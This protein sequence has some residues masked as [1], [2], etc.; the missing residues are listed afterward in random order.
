[1]ALRAQAGY[2]QPTVIVALGLRSYSEAV[3]S[4]IQELRPHLWV[5]VV[6]PGSIEQET[7][8]LAPKIVLCSLPKPTTLGSKC[9]W[10]E[11]RPYEQPTVLTV[12][13][14]QQEMGKPVELTDLVAVIDEATLNGV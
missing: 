10:I 8:R 4:V 11:Y 1:M 2:A 6:D 3:G 7:E 13:G 12:N 5:E 14:E 9:A